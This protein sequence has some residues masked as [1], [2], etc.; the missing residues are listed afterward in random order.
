MLPFASQGGVSAFPV[1]H[2]ATRPDIFISLFIPVIA[3]VA[4]DLVPFRSFPRL[5]ICDFHNK[6]HGTNSNQSNA[7]STNHGGKPSQWVS[8]DVICQAVA[9]EFSGLESREKDKCRV[10]FFANT[11]G[12]SCLFCF[13][14]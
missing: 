4:N 13:C 3:D 2:T 8:G 7:P 5:C 12:P 14:L 10:C 1:I 6:S 11:A 9:M